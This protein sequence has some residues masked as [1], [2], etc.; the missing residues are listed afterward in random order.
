MYF[1]LFPQTDPFA[2]P[3]FPQHHIWLMELDP[4]V[5][6]HEA[7]RSGSISSFQFREL[8]SIKSPAE[9]NTQF[10]SYF[11]PFGLRSFKALLSILEKAFPMC[12]ERLQELEEL[13]RPEQQNTI[14]PKP[15]EI[16][17]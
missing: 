15:S 11:R 9:H 13:C 12:V 8:S 5:L 4:G 7:Y 1:S 16:A 6:R 2:D 14:E 3:R 17:V 10:L